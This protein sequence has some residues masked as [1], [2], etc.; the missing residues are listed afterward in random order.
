MGFSIVGV[1]PGD[2]EL[3][4]IKAVRLI[5]EADIIITPIKKEGLKV[6]TA[7][8]IA[9][10]YITDLNI[11]KYLYF[12]MA[13][14]FVDDSSVKTLFKDH[15]DY[16]NSFIDL[17]LNV[18][19]ITLGDPSIYST[20]TYIAPYIKDI[21]YVPG[22][23]SFSNGAALSKIPLCIGDESLSIINM[24]DSEDNIRSV[25]A[26]SSNI[27]V[28]KVC[29]NQELLKDILTKDKR[30]FIFMSNIGLKDQSTSVELNSLDKKLPY[31]TIAIIKKCYA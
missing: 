20:F 2:S 4:T 19:F 21:N 16:I 3:I 14:G 22:I 23:T 5:K 7:L 18:V 29:S 24:T 11:V 28:M 31:F 15:G 17:D 26:T 8:S 12:P 9:E 10:P 25:F 13:M 6:S 1:G 30:D 27:V